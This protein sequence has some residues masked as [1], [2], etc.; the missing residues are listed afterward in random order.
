ML[1]ATKSILFTDVLLHSITDTWW[2]HITW[3][4]RD[5]WVASQKMCIMCCIN[6]TAYPAQCNR[7][8]SCHDW[9][10]HTFLT[11]TAQNNAID[12]RIL[13]YQ[14]KIPTQPSKSLQLQIY[15]ISPNPSKKHWA[16]VLLLI[17]SCWVSNHLLHFSIIKLQSWSRL[18]VASINA[19][20]VAASWCYWLCTSQ[21]VIII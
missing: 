20:H 18:I 8:T 2:K 5:S 7:S 4:D 13:P 19:P 21:I 16:L 1:F 10:V 9:D 14:A 17:L 12:K 15:I 6:E 3:S 11:A